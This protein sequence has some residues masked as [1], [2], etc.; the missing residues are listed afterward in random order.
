MHGSEDRYNI[1][2]NCEIH[3][4]WV[5]LDRVGVKVI[6]MLQTSIFPSVIKQELYTYFE[7][8]YTCAQKTPY[9]GLNA[10]M[11]YDTQMTVMA[12]VSIV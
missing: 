1:F 6:H 12:H 11:Y 8:P 9:R 7:R 5:D 10:N 4:L 2:S 3:G